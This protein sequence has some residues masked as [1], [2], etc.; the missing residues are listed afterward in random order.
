MR[1]ESSRSDGRMPVATWMTIS[2][3]LSLA[4]GATAG[5]D[6]LVD[7]DPGGTNSI[8]S[9]LMFNDGG[10]YQFLAGRFELSQA[11]TLDT[12]EA[13]MGPFSFAGEID[14]TIR[15][16]GAVPGDPIFS[17]TYPVAFRSAVGWDAFADN[18][19]SPNS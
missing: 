7:T 4:T 18:V 13:W 14:V 9:P 10:S 12:V 19:F 2:V 17:K 3:V 8:G 16:N 15:A 5:A 6:V 1:T 11:A